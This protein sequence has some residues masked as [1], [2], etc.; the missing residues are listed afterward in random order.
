MANTLEAPFAFVET[1]CDFKNV[2]SYRSRHLAGHD[3]HSLFPPVLYC[4]AGHE[5]HLDAPLKP[6]RPDEHDFPQ[7]NVMFSAPLAVPYLPTGHKVLVEGLG[8]KLPAGHRGQ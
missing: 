6:Y 1:V 3:L 8:Q 4:P 2:S 5:A 7:P